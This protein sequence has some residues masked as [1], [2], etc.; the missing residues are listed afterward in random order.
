MNSLNDASLSYLRW[1]GLHR[2]K[3]VWLRQP[4]PLRAAFRGLCHR[5]CT[6]STGKHGSTES[7]TFNSPIWKITAPISPALDQLLFRW[8]KLQGRVPLPDQHRESTGGKGNR[9]GRGP[10]LHCSAAFPSG[11]RPPLWNLPT[12]LSPNAGPCAGPAGPRRAPV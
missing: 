11:A 1:D 10:C 2:R 12:A 7:G 6:H 4:L 9:G 5:P 3:C 8:S